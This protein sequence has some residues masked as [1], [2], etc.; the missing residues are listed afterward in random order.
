M[1][2]KLKVPEEREYYLSFESAFDN[3]VSNTMPQFIFTVEVT[4]RR[5][6]I[7][8]RILDEALDSIRELGAAEIVNCEALGGK[9]KRRL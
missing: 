6:D 1:T 8:E 7:G 9:D 4:L 2:R 5:N 3:F